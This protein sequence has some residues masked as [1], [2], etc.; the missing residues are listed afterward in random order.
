[1][2]TR[3]VIICGRWKILYILIFF[4]KHKLA[5]NGGLE[6]GYHILSSCDF[7]DTAEEYCFHSRSEVRTILDCLSS[8]SCL[9]VHKRHQQGCSLLCSKSHKISERT[10]NHLDLIS[11]N[12]DK[13]STLD[14]LPHFWWFFSYK[15]RPVGLYGSF[16]VSAVITGTS[17]QS[18]LFLLWACA[19]SMKEST[20]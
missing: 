18:E 19:G 4:K 10:R 11:S 5:P 7:T 6:V 3:N 2:R 16:P 15:Y 17:V 12:I 20:H 9:L 14:G 8:S 13:T 1:M